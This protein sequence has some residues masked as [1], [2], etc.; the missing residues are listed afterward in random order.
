MVS[1]C[2]RYR[3]NTF[4]NT[5]RQITFFKRMDR[6]YRRDQEP[7]S[8]LLLVQLYWWI[9]LLWMCGSVLVAFVLGAVLLN[10]SY[11]QIQRVNISQSVA[12]PVFDPV[13]LHATL[14]EVLTRGNNLP[15]RLS[16]GADPSQ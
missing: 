5:M 16:P 2:A 7:E 10:E 13:E 8:R 4:A 1:Q 14:Q 6:A 12:H 3:N 15:P 11:T 9:A